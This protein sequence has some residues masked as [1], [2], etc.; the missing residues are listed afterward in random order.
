MV[1]VQYFSILADVFSNDMLKETLS[2]F[3]ITI[4][5]D[6]SSITLSFYISTFWMI[7]SH[8]AIKLKL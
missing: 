3:K 1:K 4:L 8:F 7:L 5:F 2:C 6:V